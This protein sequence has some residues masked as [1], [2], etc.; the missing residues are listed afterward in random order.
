MR[1]SASPSPQYSYVP[2]IAAPCGPDHYSKL[3]IAEMD[4][5]LDFWNMMAY[6]FCAS[7]ASCMCT[8]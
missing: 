7:P 6:D 1:V 2:Q 4:R 8:Y 5:S 3:H